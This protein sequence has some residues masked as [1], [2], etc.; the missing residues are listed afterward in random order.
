[1][2]KK[3]KPI[4]GPC[5][6]KMTKRK[7]EPSEFSRYD[8]YVNGRLNTEYTYNATFEGFSWDKGLNGALLQLQAA[9]PLHAFFP[10]NPDVYALNEDAPTSKIQLRLEPNDIHITLQ[11]RSS[12]RRR[13]LRSPPRSRSEADASA[14]HHGHRQHISRVRCRD[15]DC[16]GVLRSHSDSPLYRYVP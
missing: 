11:P 16:R 6:S 8:R 3:F 4:F 14:L 12:R 10:S 1:M 13:S 5:T 2:Y 9:R 7:I 15:R